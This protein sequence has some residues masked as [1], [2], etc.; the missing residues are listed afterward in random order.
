M[1]E[2]LKCF[3]FGTERVIWRRCSNW[4]TT[5]CVQ[6]THGTERNGG[7]ANGDDSPGDPILPSSCRSW[8]RHVWLQN[9]RM[10]TGPVTAI[11]APRGH[12]G[13]GRRQRGIGACW[14][15]WALVLPLRFSFLRMRR[16]I[17]VYG[18]KSNKNKQESPRRAAVA[19][20]CAYLRRSTQRAVV[21]VRPYVLSLI[22]V[23]QRSRMIISTERATD[24]ANGFFFFFLC[25][26]ASTLG[27]I[28]WHSKWRQM[29]VRIQRT[30]RQE[31][32]DWDGWPAATWPYNLL[33]TQYI[34]IKNIKA[35]KFRNVYKS[36]LTFITWYFSNNKS[37]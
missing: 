15:P 32:T 20:V 5:Y 12:V 37:I 23:V 22:G 36:T 10:S 13:H 6:L 28:L 2:S 29:G 33:P 18:G 21:L 4:P 31:A 3:F 9:V 34:Q 1:F 27:W 19:L 24:S 25:V 7:E 35:H 17:V 26:W 11:G 14:P 30:Q 8:K 16:R